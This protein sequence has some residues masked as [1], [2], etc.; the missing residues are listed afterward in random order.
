LRQE[1]AAREDAEAASR[2]KDEFLATVSHELRTPLTAIMGWASV[3]LDESLPVSQVRHAVEVIVRSA[4]SQSELIADILDMSR[5]VTGKLK[6]DARPVEIESVFQ[7][8]VDV[9]RPS[10][11]AKRIAL[12]AVADGRHRLVSGDANRL[13]QAIWNLLANAVKF[14]GEGGRIEAQLSVASGQAEITIMDTGI[15]IEPQFMPSVFERFRQFDSSST[16]RYGG[17]GLG[18][19]IV[20]HVV[21]MHGGTVFVSSPGKGQGSTFRINLPLI[22]AP[23]ARLTA[24]LSSESDA[25]EASPS[26]K[27]SQPLAN[28]RVL[29]VEDDPDTLDLLKL[30][31][32]DSG[33][34]IA[35]APSA[36][37]AVNVFEHW[38]PDVLVSDLALPDQDGYQLIRQVRSR[39]SQQG[40]NIPAVA[41][42]A[43]AR[44]E[45]RS[46]ALAAGFQMHL[47]KPIVPKELIAALAHLFGRGHG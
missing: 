45:D 27:R 21:E 35:T 32:D 39:S 2:I 8:A 13:Q 20:R 4:K 14:T 3:L 12:H 16:R 29:V 6:L 5:V 26:Q 41:L 44:S 33:A 46:R 1:K 42:T 17:L 38:R 18:L 34:D 37:E 11:E 19:A 36:R 43:Y 40:G 30:V 7:A 25:A 31:L 24:A 9:V 23:D 47:A 22:A 15:G 10:A 28:M